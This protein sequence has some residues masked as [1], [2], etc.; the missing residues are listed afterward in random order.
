MAGRDCALLLAGTAQVQYRWV[1]IF[2]WSLRRGCV[3]MTYDDVTEW[4]GRLAQGDQ[5]AV[6]VIWERYFSRLVRLAQKRLKSLPRRV[7]DEEDVALSAFHSFYRGMAAGR[8]P[9]LS[10]RRDLWRLLVTITARKA[11]AQ[12]K[13]HV[14]QKRGAGKVRGESA[15][16][17]GR[18][19]PIGGIDRVLGREPSPEL[20]AMLAETCRHLLGRLD[21]ETLRTVALCK[22]EGCDC[23]EIAERLSCTVRTV[24]RK[25]QRIAEKWEHAGL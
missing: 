15:L 6:E 25:L 9:R 24:Q 2:R 3:A 23:E 19:E 5:V 17:G 4:L 1:I 22:L 7:A 16:G 21:D 11:A 13:R 14:A 20:A 18:S 12:F 8:F 10:D